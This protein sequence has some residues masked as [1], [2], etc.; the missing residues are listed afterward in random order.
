MGLPWYCVHT[1]VSN[2]LGRLL[3][4]HIMLTTLV[5]GWARLM[6]LYDLAVF[7]PADPV[8]LQENNRKP[9]KAA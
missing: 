8:S 9:P 3:W 4:V 1:I 7:D 5:S 2:D 6:A